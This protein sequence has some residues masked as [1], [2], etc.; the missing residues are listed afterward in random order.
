MCV[1]VCEISTHTTQAELGTFCFQFHELRPCFFYHTSDQATLSVSN[2]SG[3]PGEQHLW[4][5]THIP[6]G[7]HTGRCL[8]V[9]KVSSDEDGM[10]H[11]VRIMLTNQVKASGII[12]GNVGEDASWKKWTVTERATESTLEVNELPLW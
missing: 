11:L 1:S 3:A 10:V 5:L 8:L 12:N 7:W 6:W 9:L 2:M 4:L